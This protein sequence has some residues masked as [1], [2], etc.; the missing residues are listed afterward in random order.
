MNSLS[1][2]CPRCKSELEVSDLG[3]VTCCA[4]T[5]VFK[6]I[7]EPPRLDGAGRFNDVQCFFAEQETGK[8]AAFKKGQHISVGGQVYGTYLGLVRLKYCVLE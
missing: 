3:P 7:G 4:C 2:V 5:H 8:A 6:A 1:V